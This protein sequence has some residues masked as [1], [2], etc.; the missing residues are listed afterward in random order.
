MQFTLEKKK[1]TVPGPAESSVRF[2]CDV[3]SI[4]MPGDRKE[5]YWQKA[6]K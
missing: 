6:M 3:S 1:Y 2:G 5:K 4:S